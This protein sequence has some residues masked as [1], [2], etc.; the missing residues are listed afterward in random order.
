[1]GLHAGFQTFFS[2]IPKKTHILCGDSVHKHICI[3]KNFKTIPLTMS[4]A[5][6]DLLFDFTIKEI[7]IV[8]H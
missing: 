5:L 2:T 8:T 4:D 1:M 3:N 7:L 6:R